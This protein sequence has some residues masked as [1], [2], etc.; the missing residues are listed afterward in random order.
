MKSAQITVFEK[1]EVLYSG[2][3]FVHTVYK[4]RHSARKKLIYALF[5][6]MLFIIL[7]PPSLS[8]PFERLRLRFVNLFP[9]MPRYCQTVR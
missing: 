1:F 9:F 5:A 7:P 3:A 8:L 4:N 2:H 6:R